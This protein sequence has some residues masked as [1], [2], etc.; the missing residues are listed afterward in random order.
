MKE[1]S[2]DFVLEYDAYC[3]EVIQRYCVEMKKVNIGI[4]MTLRLV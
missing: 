2:F 3:R 4:M 1:K